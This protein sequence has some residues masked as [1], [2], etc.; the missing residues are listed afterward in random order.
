MPLALLVSITVLAHVAYNGT[1]LTFSLAALSQGA[2]PLTVGA[3]V[4]LMA[5]LPMALGA[6]SGR[7]VDRIGVRRPLILGTAG[8][9]AGV[10]LAALF[11]SLAVFPV[12]AAVVGSSFAIV[13]ICAQ[14]MVGEMSAPARRR[15]NFSLLA[16]GFSISNF[17]GPTVSGLAID[18]FGFRATFCI[19][20]AFACAALTILFAHRA[21][22]QHKAHHTRDKRDRSA[23]ELLRDPELRRVLI[24]SGMLASAWDLFTFVMPIYGTAIGLSATT[25]GL[26]LGSFA[27]ATFAVRA[28]LPWIQRH[29]HEW[30]LITATFAVA[31]LA[32]AAFPLVRTVP[33]LAVLSFV[34]GFGLG[35]TQPSIMALLYATAPAGRAAEAVGLRTVALNASTTVFPVLFGGLGAA[36]GI[37]PVFLAM[38]VA[39]AG[40]AILSRR[41]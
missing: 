39:L 34:L 23:L 30:P 31:C 17:L 20:A 33:L 27:A 32:Y 1:R 5:A 40:G 19:L 12:V 3:L 24:V 26:I 15:H 36:V 14:H 11:P 4:S 6:F 25:I 38:A 28:L 16:L 10:V 41:R 8:V 35:A 29:I 9:I 7:L 13:H 18:H 2:T 22:L 21:K 37:A